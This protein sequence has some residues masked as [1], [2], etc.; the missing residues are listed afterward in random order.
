MT[1]EQLPLVLIHGID[2]TPAVFEAMVQYL[3][4]LGWTHLHP[5]SLTPNN[6]DVGLDILAQQVSSYIAA[7]LP[8]PT[9][10]D[11]LGFSMGGIVSRYYLQRLGG[12]QQVRRFLTLSSP[13][14]GTWTGYLRPNLG[15]TQMR[16]NSPFLMDL[17]RTLSQLEQ[18]EFTSVWTPYDLMIVP[19]ESSQLP[20]GKSIQVPVLAHP[21]MLTDERSLQVVAQVLS[22]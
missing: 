3:R 8:I 21:W 7:H 11:L 15:A 16:P 14:N 22:V 6:G 4:D 2:D 17:N 1:T 13:H 10:F 5:I 9:T 12:L 19:A 18:V 20:I